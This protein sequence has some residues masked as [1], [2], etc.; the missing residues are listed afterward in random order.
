MAAKELLIIIISVAAAA[1]AQIPCPPAF[2]TISRGELRG[3]ALPGGADEFLGIEFATAPR[4]Q[5]AVL[6]TTHFQKKPEDA[7]YFGPAC[8]QTLTQNT[9][10][11]S[12][13]CLVV[14]SC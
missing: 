12:E 6:S 5:K 9:T 1:N 14:R 7:T 11:G 8:L 2:A 13:S 10:Y 3:N 4:Y